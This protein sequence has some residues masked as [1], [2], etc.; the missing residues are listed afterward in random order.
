MR[1]VARKVVFDACELRVLGG[2]SLTH[3]SGADDTSSCKT[4]LHPLETKGYFRR[5]KKRENA[6]EKERES[7]R[8]RNTNR[9]QQGSEDAFDTITPTF[10][11][12]WGEKEKK[13]KPLD[14]ITPLTAH[15]TPP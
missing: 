9:Q 5:E 8:E 11:P 12:V 4:Q 7:E 6:W 1:S 10:D 13:D 15:L 2:T 3:T 14:I